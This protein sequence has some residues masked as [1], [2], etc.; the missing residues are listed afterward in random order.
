MLRLQFGRNCAN[1]VHGGGQLPD[2]EES[3]RARISGDGHSQLHVRPD[4]G[5]RRR[6][7]A[8][9]GVGQEHEVGQQADQHQ[10]TAGHTNNWIISS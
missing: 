7:R 8:C 3:E 1:H 6:E 5:Q 10:V 9:A 4:H 2:Q